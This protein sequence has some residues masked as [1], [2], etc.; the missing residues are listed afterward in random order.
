MHAVQTVS[1]GRV[2][3]TELLPLLLSLWLFAVIRRRSMLNPATGSNNVLVVALYWIVGF[4]LTAYLA[5]YMGLYLVGLLKTG[6]TI[7]TTLASQASL[8]T[9]IAIYI[10][11]LF[12]ALIPYRLL[13]RQGKTQMWIWLVI[14][15]VYAI[16]F[17][18]FTFM[19]R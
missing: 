6:Q 11:G 14:A 7:T 10:S 3:I 16:L 17:F 1:W 19:V 4:M 18:I 15:A 9:K 8:V 2:I 5:F 12:G 13:A